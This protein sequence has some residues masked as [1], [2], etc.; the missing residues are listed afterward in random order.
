[1]TI[2]IA[3]SKNPLRN[4]GGLKLKSGRANAKLNY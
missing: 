1:M 2:V 3:T 4:I